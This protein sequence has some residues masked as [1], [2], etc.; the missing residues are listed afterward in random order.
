M[1]NLKPIAIK[2]IKT[3]WIV[4]LE[5]DL[6]KEIL[7]RPDRFLAQTINHKAQITLSERKEEW[8]PYL[9]V[10]GIKDNNKQEINYMFTEI[11]F[12]NGLKATVRTNNECK[13][14]FEFSS[15][16]TEEEISIIEEFSK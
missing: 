1:I 4:K 8:Q 13:L 7:Y 2:L 9:H 5:H 15:L 3:N 10:V 6:P 14:M 12:D 11:F 16:L